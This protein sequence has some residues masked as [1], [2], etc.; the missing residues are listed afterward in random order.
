MKWFGEL[1]SHIIKIQ[2]NC[3][4]DNKSYSNNSFIAIKHEHIL[5]FKKNKIWIFNTKVTN[6]I[7]ENIMNVKTIK[8]K[9]LKWLRFISM[10]LI[11]EKI[12]IVFWQI[13]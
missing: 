7:K 4:S 12:F 9:D 2:H 13:I 10:F 1:E 5:I 11:K 3:F 6:T 8:T